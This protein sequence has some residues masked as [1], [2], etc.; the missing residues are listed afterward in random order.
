MQ[1]QAVAQQWLSRD[2]SAAAATG[3]HSLKADVRKV[4]AI[5]H[6]FARTHGF[7]RGQSGAGSR[8]GC[9]IGDHRRRQVRRVRQPTNGWFD[10]DSG[11]ADRVRESR[12]GNLG[13]LDSLAQLIL[14][15]RQFRVRS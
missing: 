3:E 12:A 5:E 14:G 1:P 6:A 2:L 9:Q 13:G 7:D 10:R 15:D 8:M 11:G 4:R